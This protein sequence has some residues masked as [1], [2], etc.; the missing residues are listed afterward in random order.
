MSHLVN[1]LIAMMSCFPAAPLDPLPIGGLVEDAEALPYDIGA[2]ALEA[3]PR[4]QGSAESRSRRGRSDPA[5]A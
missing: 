4:S 5:A 2:D 3:A 1:R